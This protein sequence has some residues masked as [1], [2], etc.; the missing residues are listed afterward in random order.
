[1]P[2]L[3]KELQDIVQT[4]VAAEDAYSVAPDDLVAAEIEILTR[5]IGHIVEKTRVDQA[6]VDSLAKAARVTL[7]KQKA[8]YAAAKAAVDKLRAAKASDAARARAE[9][10]ELI[11]TRGLLV[12]IVVALI[13]L[14]FIA[15]S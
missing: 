12:L 2:E 13:G 10:D 11:E 7:E 6:Y 15:K 3:L 14:F 4:K 5:C 9:S 8:G 1:M